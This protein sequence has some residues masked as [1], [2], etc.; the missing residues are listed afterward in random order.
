MSLVEVKQKSGY[1][2]TIKLM[3]DGQFSGQVAKDGKHCS[4]STKIGTRDEVIAAAKTYVAWHQQNGE[5]ADEVIP[6]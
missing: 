4:G 5:T 3:P 1:E 2:L 6:L